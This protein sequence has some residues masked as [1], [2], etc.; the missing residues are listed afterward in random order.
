LFYPTVDFQSRNTPWVGAVEENF[1][2]E[3]EVFDWIEV[4]HTGN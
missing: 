1:A 2:L 4:V 3:N